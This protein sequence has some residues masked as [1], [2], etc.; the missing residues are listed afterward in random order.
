MT[1]LAANDR[2]NFIRVSAVAPL[3]S[4]RD[5]AQA[6]ALLQ[7]L[8]NDPAAVVRGRAVPPSPTPPT[9]RPSPARARPVEHIVLLAFAPINRPRAS[10]VQS[11]AARVRPQPIHENRRRPPSAQRRGLNSTV[12]NL[13]QS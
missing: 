7:Q 4:L 8:A 3:I 11:P 6:L 10:A 1:T 5:N 9:P 13:H 12:I 2:D